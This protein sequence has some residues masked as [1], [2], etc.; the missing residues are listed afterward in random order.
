VEDAHQ[1][2]AVQAPATQ[3]HN[4]CTTQ[5]GLQEQV[6]AASTQVI[7]LAFQPFLEASQTLEC[8]PQCTGHVAHQLV[9]D[10][11]PAMEVD[12][13]QFPHTLYQGLLM[14]DVDLAVLPM[15]L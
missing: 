1:V 11:G 5:A 10:V 13:V 15:E 3:H 14:E 6:A 4:P 2:A 7:Q 12:G 8:L 9:E